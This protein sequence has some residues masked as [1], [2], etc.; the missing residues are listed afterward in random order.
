MLML[1]LISAKSIN[2][3]IAIVLSFFTPNF[4]V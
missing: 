1:F 3:K 2:C 4:A